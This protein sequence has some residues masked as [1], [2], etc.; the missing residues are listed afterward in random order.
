M[1]SAMKRFI[2][3]VL[4]L[5]SLCGGVRASDDIVLQSTSSDCGPAA[6]ATLLKVY[7]GI[8]T[9]EAEMVTLTKSKPQFGT[10]LLELE[11][12]ATQKGCQADSFRMDWKTLQAQLAS[13]PLPLI[14]R[15]QN[16]EPHFS[17]LLA[18]KDGTVYMADPATGHVMLSEKAFLKRWLVPKED[19]GYAFIAIGSE[20]YI[21]QDKHTQV[22]KRLFKQTQ[23]LQSLQ[24]YS[25]TFR[26]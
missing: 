14:V 4:I 6:L 10:T 22:L 1:V 23:N 20:G 18:V 13:Y 21:N 26:R 19:T 3:P 5:V 24:L 15:T 9:T 12:A 11:L 8:P 2:L 7:L 16:P 25:P 17:V